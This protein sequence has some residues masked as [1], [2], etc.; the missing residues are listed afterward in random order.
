MC[1]ILEIQEINGMPCLWD[2]PQKIR[3][4]WQK[5]HANGVE[6]VKRLF[7]YDQY[8]ILN[9]QYQISIANTANTT[10]TKEK[11]IFDI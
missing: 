10:N 5:R 8:I 11:L 9:C 7:S 2:F 1:I 4:Q 3:H 6:L